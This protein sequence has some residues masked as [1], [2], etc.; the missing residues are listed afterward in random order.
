MRLSECKPSLSS[1]SIATLVGAMAISYTYGLTLHS[2]PEEMLGA[3][4]IYKRID[5]AHVVDENGGRVQEF[6]R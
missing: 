1:T 2:I 5:G 6:S 3:I 4:S